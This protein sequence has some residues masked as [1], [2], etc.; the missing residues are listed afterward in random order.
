MIFRKR[1][2]D[3]KVQTTDPDAV[4]KGALAPWDIVIIQTKRSSHD[5]RVGVPGWKS[6]T[7]K[8]K[9]GR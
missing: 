7:D 3:A 9:A 6:F 2:V 8:V 5:V 1:V 4:V